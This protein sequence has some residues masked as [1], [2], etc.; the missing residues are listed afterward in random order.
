MIRIPNPNQYSK[1]DNKLTNT[2]NNE[3]RVVGRS[4]IY[5]NNMSIV[6][7]IVELLFIFIYSHKKGYQKGI[8]C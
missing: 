2:M 3:D 7:T 4:S 1:A 8:L 5:N 6:V